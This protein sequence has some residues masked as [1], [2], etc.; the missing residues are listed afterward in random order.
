MPADGRNNGGPLAVHRRFALRVRLRLGRALLVESGLVAAAASGGAVAVLICRSRWVGTSTGPVLAAITA[1]IGAVAAVHVVRRWPTL[2]AAADAADR[3]FGWDDLLLSAVQTSGVPGDLTAAVWAAADIRCEESRPARVPVPVRSR[4]VIGS[5]L[6]MVAAV[7]AIVCVR[8]SSGPTTAIRA[9]ADAVLT[10]DV[11]APPSD[12]RSAASIRPPPPPRVSASSDD[13]R[14]STPA[15]ESSAGS[16]PGSG[17]PA[18]AAAA[19]GGAGRGRASSPPAVAASAAETGF[20]AA[21]VDRGG[22]LAGGGTSARPESGLSTAGVGRVTGV[23]SA[24]VSAPWRA[25]G[26]AAPVDAAA[27][28]RSVPVADRPL[29]RAYFDPTRRP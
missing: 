27:L 20:G 8:P 17:K 5:C 7:T 3:H 16:R 19:A 15:D 29:V 28:A 4:T 18:A 24:P 25:T 13:R 12:A 10:A 9:E 23:D 22:S 11:D 21:G 1:L 26:P 2:A 14:W 6:V